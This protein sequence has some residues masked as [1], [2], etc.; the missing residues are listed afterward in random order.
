MKKMKIST[1]LVIGVV[2]ISL[3]VLI[4]LF[5]IINIYIRGLVVEQV[6]MG[7]DNNNIIMAGEVDDW[8]GTYAD[9]VA[10]MSLAVTGLP[11]EFMYGVTRNFQAYHPGINLAFIGFPTGFAIANHGQPPEEGWRAY[12]R[13]WYIA[14]MRNPGQIVIDKPFFSATEQRWATSAS[15]LIPDIGDGTPA[16]AAFVVTLDHLHGIMNSFNLGNG[17]YAFLIGSNGD[18]ITHYDRAFAPTDRL[19]NL[20]NSPLYR[21]VLPRMLALEDY[22]PFTMANGRDAYILTHQLESA[23][24]I[25]VSVI[26]A[27]VKNAAVNRMVAVVITV[28]VIGLAAL[29]F[30]TIIA[31]SRMLR[32]GIGGAV[33]S[34]RDSSA[35]LARGEG[36]KISNWKDKSFG[37]DAMSREFED[38]LQIIANIIQDVS[39]MHHELKCGNYTY[40]LDL[41]KYDGAYAAIMNDVNDVLTGLM[42]SRT[43]IIEHFQEVVDGNF[44]A[45]L[46]RL[47][48]A[49]AYINEIADNVKQAIINLAE[50]IGDMAAHA[51]K[52]NLGYRL[53][54]ALYKGEWIGIVNQLNKVMEA[55]A[56]PI[57]ETV[58]VL[59][60][61]EQGDFSRQVQGHYL[62]E[63]LTIKEAINATG[64]AT[65]SYV[66]DIS[67]V[68]NKIASGDLTVTINRDFAG[69]YAPIKTALTVILKSLNEIMSEISDAVGQVANGAEQISHNAM[70]LAEGATRQT[71]SIEELSSS[72]MLIHEKS[73][74]ASN[75]AVL[76]S[77]SAVA[78][79]QCVEAG[80]E[81]VKAL[82]DSMTQ[83]KI[84]GESI[85]KVI[86]VMSNIAFST[87]L[88]AL[89]ASVEAA[90]AGEAGR[91]FSVVADEVRTLANA[92]QKSS[93][94]TA[95]IIDEDTKN[96]NNGLAATEDVVASFKVIA[97]NIGEVSALVSKIAAMA[98]EQL[99]SVSVI[100][101]S[102][103]EIT[104][105]VTAT[106]A[107]AEE[108]AAA[109]QEL[110]SQSEMLRQKVAF[111]KLK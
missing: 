56:E 63:F 73:T 92:S 83:V 66:N 84:S 80:D 46:R 19:F 95:I 77:D 89:N 11:T 70:N 74:Q 7:Y 75:S 44:K 57:G 86:D 59:E 1:K 2:S 69:S 36:L 97:K 8:I 102:V 60:A 68:L 98:G 64:Q 109:A 79:N 58:R 49:E 41:S 12:E 37:M 33:A 72:L 54:P 22:V 51:Q 47:P 32:K 45:V 76:A 17:G 50:A 6:R 103:L 38:N 35:S 48:G 9:L 34:F 111:F 52:G 23:D 108:S 27:S 85:A 21:D 99:D 88:L 25:M 5:L 101:S 14:A 30:F 24:W 40:R 82:T 10:G 90:R 31:I 39:K 62:G 78:A 96:I 61:I 3:V 53:N 28:A 104:D 87:N 94:E 81:A 91:S 106:S 18:V 42:N 65:L 55:V 100:N 4:V 67:E 26:P 110:S 16:V 15:V 13:P 29:T 105:V 107:V 43:E 20:Q 71:A 93:A